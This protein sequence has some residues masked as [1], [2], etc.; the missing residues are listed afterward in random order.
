MSSEVQGQDFGSPS[1]LTERVAGWCVITWSS[2]SMRPQ[3]RVIEL[4]LDP[5][6]L[7]GRPVEV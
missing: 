6:N 1:D 3:A 5:Y 7:P 4:F 2:K